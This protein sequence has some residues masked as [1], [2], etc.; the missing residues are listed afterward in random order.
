MSERILIVGGGVI[1]LSA[2]LNARN[3]GHQVTVIEGAHPWQASSAA[4]GV[5]FPTSATR[6]VGWPGHY[7]LRALD[8]WP[9]YERLLGGNLTRGGG[10]VFLDDESGIEDL[11]T[12][13]E[14][15]KCEVEEIKAPPQYFDKP[16]SFCLEIKQGRVTQPPEV[17]RRLRSACQ[18]ILRRDTAKELIIRGGRAVAVAGESGQYQADHIVVAG[19]ALG[20]EWLPEELRPLLI[21]TQG[22]AL[23]LK[24][25]ERPPLPAALYAFSEGPLVDYGNN[26][27]WLGGSYHKSRGEGASWEE[28]RRII[29]RGQELFPW[30]KEAKIQEMVFGLRPVSPD[31]L[32]FVGPSKQEGLL[33][34]CGHGKDGILQAPL[35]AEQILSWIEKDLGEERLLPGRKV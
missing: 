20:C 30:I 14:A 28:I 15:A 1:G 29:S 21:P 2:A 8:L 23:L 6:C 11:K 3:R 25:K 35:L 4:A 13:A 12:I 18:K 17:L 10:I 27:L 24:L 33:F 22:E 16:A 5:L 7:S 32:P 34:A 31:G 19:G 9:N 26:T